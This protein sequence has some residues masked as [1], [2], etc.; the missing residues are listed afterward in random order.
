ML[1]AGSDTPKSA[2]YKSSFD[3]A[4]ALHHGS[5]GVEVP[6]QRGDIF[7]ARDWHGGA[8]V[9]GEHGLADVRQGL[10]LVYVRAQLEQLQ[11]TFMI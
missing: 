10:I 5:A 2:Y 8:G 6:D 7:H 11:D 1:G 9:R 3:L 4:S